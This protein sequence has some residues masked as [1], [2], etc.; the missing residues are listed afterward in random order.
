MCQT[1]KSFHESCLA[2][3]SSNKERNADSITQTPVLLFSWPCNWS[4]IKCTLEAHYSKR[5]L[6]LFYIQM[7]QGQRKW[8]CRSHLPRFHVKGQNAKCKI[9]NLNWKTKHGKGIMQNAQVYKCQ[10]A[11]THK[12]RILRMI[13]CPLRQTLVPHRP[14]PGVKMYNK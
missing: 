5:R 9:Q 3:C 8:F 6:L 2:K 14:R 4:G 12:G 11:S 13:F 1:K 10:N 7:L